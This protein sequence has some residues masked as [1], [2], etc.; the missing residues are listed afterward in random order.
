[1]TEDIATIQLRRAVKWVA[2]LNLSYFGVEFAVAGAIGSVPKSGSFDTLL[3]AVITAAMD[4]PLMTESERDKWCIQEKIEYDPV[5]QAAD[6][7]GVKVEI[8]MMFLRPDDEP[9]PILAQNL[10]RLSRGKMLG[11]D[12][13]KQFTWVGSSVGLSLTS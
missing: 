11:V 10:I 9:R 4:A 6:G 13:N 3:K 2:A 12:F 7:G 8:R 5:L 1:M